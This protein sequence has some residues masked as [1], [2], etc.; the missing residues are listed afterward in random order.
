[1]FELV[2]GLDKTANDTICG[3]MEHYGLNSKA[4][5]VSKALSILKVA[6]Y[7]EST[8]GELIARKGEHESLLKI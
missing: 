7:I 6:A 2:L 4:E 1:M 3:L 8:N 5:L